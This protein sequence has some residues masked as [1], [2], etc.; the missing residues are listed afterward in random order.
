[1]TDHGRHGG[2][3]LILT[4]LR[5]RANHGVFDFE[6]E[7]GQDFLIDVTAWLDLSP[8]AAGDDLSRTVH[9]GEL[10]VEIADAV[11]R[12]PVDLIET[13]AERIAGI[14]LA[15]PPVDAVEVTVHKPDAPIP[16]PFE[17]VA[18]R[19]LRRRS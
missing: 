16:E 9:Y 12:D 11:R 10:A 7:N 19:I 6:R 15:H 14:V 13:V 1:M 17:D 18:V 4:G 8:S 3:T 5:V 2:D